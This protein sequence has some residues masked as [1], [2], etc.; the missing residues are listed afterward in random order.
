MIRDPTEKNEDISKNQ[1]IKESIIWR[2]R[3]DQRPKDSE[4]NYTY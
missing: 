3:S 1:T 2:E 4:R